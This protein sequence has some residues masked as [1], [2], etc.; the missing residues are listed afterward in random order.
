M[1]QK[2]R[3]W[4]LPTRLFH[5]L[6]ALVILGAFITINLD[7]TELHA[8]FGYAACVLVIFRIIWGFVGPEHA[9]FSNF[10]PSITQLK[11][12]IK[13]PVYDK[14]GHN[15]LGALSVIGLLLVVLVQTTSG[16]FT[17][18]EISFQGPLSHLVS[19]QIAGFLTGLHE[20]NSNLVY[21]LVGLHLAAIFYYQKVKK[22]NLIGPMLTGDKEITSEEL[23]TPTDL[24]PSKDHGKV[25]GLALAILMVIAVGFYFLVIKK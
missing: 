20:I 11:A 24:T 12:F 15:P 13:H 5:W 8:K 2:I 25:R 1:L 6:F 19:S 23:K 22:E 4:D 3:V 16:L 21:A 10:V 18:D 9:R 17:D 14:L 7:E